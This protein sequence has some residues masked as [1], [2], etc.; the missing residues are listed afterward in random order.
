[1]E[2]K[3]L[4][5]FDKGLEIIKRFVVP[6]GTER[7]DLF[8]AL[9]RTLAEDVFADVSMPPFNK[10]AMD[11]YACRKSDMK[12][13]LQVIEEIPAGSVP[14]KTIGANQCS[15]IMT[16]AMV[17]EGADWIIM[18]EH[19]EEVGPNLVLCVRELGNSNICYAGEDVKAGDMVIRKGYVISPAHI[20]ILASVGCVNPLVYNLPS[21]AVFST[22]DELVEPG[23]IPG[24]S[25]IRNSNSYQL[26]AQPQQMGITPEYLGIVP[27]NEILLKE[28]LESALEKY[29]VILISGGVSVGDFDFVPR[30]L[31]QL[32]VNIH[33]HGM[34]VKPGKHLL[35]GEKN[36]HFVFGMPGNPVSSFVQFEVLVKPFLN[37]LMGKTSKETVL[38]LPLEEDYFRK[39]ADQLFFVPVTITA[40]GTIIPIEY[41]GS[42]HIHAYTMAHGIMEIPQGVLNLKKGEISGVRPL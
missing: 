35:F 21:V 27:D 41:H 11:G 28:V 16:G 38:H 31:K 20:A 13:T 33:V 30:I 8:H 25:K 9:N 3:T 15:R 19:I 34:N 40:N 1:M 23:E 26:I 24:I 36:N 22:G 5:S 14:K 17:P 29:D 6:L 4:I 37:A 42:A 18:K 39:K 7:I 32:D 10:S 12:N 2:T